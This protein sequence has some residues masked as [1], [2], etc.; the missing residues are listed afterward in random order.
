MECFGDLAFY[1]WGTFRFYATIV[2]FLLGAHTL[3]YTTLHYSI[4]HT[5]AHTLLY[6]THYTAVYHTL[7]QRGV[8][9]YTTLQ[10]STLYIYPLPVI[11]PLIPPLIST[12]YFHP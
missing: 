4:P 6:I 5:V 1:M 2:L 8:K 12:L 3:H 11:P 9:H 7:L 10:L